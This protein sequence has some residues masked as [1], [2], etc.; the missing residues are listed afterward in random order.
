MDLDLIRYQN[1]GKK[2]FS[3]DKEE[4]TFVDEK[5]SELI[6][7]EEVS[8][9]EYI[10]YFGEEV[11]ERFYNCEKVS[12]AFLREMIVLSIE[13]LKEGW[14]SA[15]SETDVEKLLD[16]WIQEGLW[17]WRF[18]VKERNA[19]GEIVFNMEELIEK[20]EEKEK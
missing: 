18:E 5:V 17:D 16:E 10:I 3:S 8:L 14:E 2:V 15:H 20:G 1:G 4:M 9:D 11:H 12:E 19:H 7:V 6:R 13:I